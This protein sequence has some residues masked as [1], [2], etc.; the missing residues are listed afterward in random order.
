M[1]LT[2]GFIYVYYCNW[3]RPPHDKI[4]LCICKD[5]NWVFWFNSNAK[6]HNI[7]QLP[8]EGADHSTALR[9]ACF[10]DVSGVKEMSASEVRNCVDRGEISPAFKARILQA[11]GQ[12]IKTLPEPH[13][14]LAIAALK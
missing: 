3:I 1:P 8:C 7:G 11:L 10:L 6:F 4:A 13:R 2:N 9:K 14:A 5:S 12:P